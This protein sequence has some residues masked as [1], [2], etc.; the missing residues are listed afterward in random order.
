VS[1]FYTARPVRARKA[2]KCRGCTEPINPGTS[3]VMEAG[4]TEGVF[5]AIRKHGGCA[6][7]FGAINVVLN[8]YL[9]DGWDDPDSLVHDYNPD[10]AEVA[11][12]LDWDGGHYE[13]PLGLPLVALGADEQD[14]VR[15]LLAAYVADAAAGRA[16]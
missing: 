7:L 10:A 16:S 15:R 8:E 2:H 3:Y 5:W 6:W 12:V 13:W 11:R 1:D 4:A 14:R 9:S